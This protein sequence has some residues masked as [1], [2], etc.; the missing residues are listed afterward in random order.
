MYRFPRYA[1]AR[2]VLVAINMR[3]YKTF[4]RYNESYFLI[5][6]FVY[7]V[8]SFP[9]CFHNATVS[10][11]LFMRFIRKRYCISAA[12]IVVAVIFTACADPSTNSY[13]PHFDASSGIGDVGGISFKMIKIAAVKNGSVG[14]DSE[15]TNPEH[16]VNLRSYM[17][18]ET[19]VTQELW[20][21]VMGTNP[22]NSIKPAA[23]GEVQSK[24]PVEEVNWFDAIAFCNELTKRVYGSDRE[25]VYHLKGSPSVI[26]APHH[27]PKRGEYAKY[28]PEQDMSKKGFRL[29][30]EAEWEW[31]AKGGQDFKW[32]G[33]GNKDQLKHY[34]WYGWYKDDG[35]QDGGDAGGKTHQVKLKRPNGY[36]L[37][38]M[39]GNVCEWCWDRYEDEDTVPA[40]VPLDYAGETGDLG[41]RRVRRS[42]GLC[43]GSKEA[44]CAFRTRSGPDYWTYDT[45][46]RLV[47]RP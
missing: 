30:T 11:R 27:A 25:C 22:S 37:Y 45:G 46:L 44:T 36:G 15:T 17:I 40:S 33:T 26:Y 6:I 34:A 13:T 5:W 4:F 12:V 10:R 8:N 24:R 19:E 35:D 18:G 3:K 42:G 28:M 21:A 43:F 23:S 29:P 14:N 2:P 39:S 1:N 7:K 16:K 9:L 31:A 38:D 41:D 20:Q 47:C 32:A